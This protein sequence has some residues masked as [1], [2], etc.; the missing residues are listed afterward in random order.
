MNSKTEGSEKSLLKSFTV[1]PGYEIFPNMNEISWK[2]KHNIPF[3]ARYNYPTLRKQLNEVKTLIQLRKIS[4]LEALDFIGT[5]MTCCSET[6]WVNFISEVFD[7]LDIQDKLNI[8]KSIIIE[9]LEDNSEHIIELLNNL[10]I[11]V[12]TESANF[13]SESQEIILMNTTFLDTFFFKPISS[14]KPRKL[15]KLSNIISKLVIN[16]V[17][18]V[19]KENKIRCLEIMVSC[20]FTKPLIKKHHWEFLL[21]MLSDEQRNIEDF[22]GRIIGIF[23]QSQKKKYIKKAYE[24]LHSNKSRVNDDPNNSHYFELTDKA[25]EDISKCIEIDI[26]NEISNEG[27]SILNESEFKKL[28]DILIFSINSNFEYRPNVNLISTLIFVWTNITDKKYFINELLQFGQNACGYGLMMNMV[29]FLG[30]EYI[31]INEIYMQKDEVVKYIQNNELDINENI[32]DSIIE[33]CKNLGYNSEKILK[34]FNL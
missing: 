3:L 11:K 24:L 29:T 34:V 10:F 30:P 8:L 2:L 17:D 20:N 4:S 9:Y 32:K 7:F 28:I 22:S 5:I 15:S 1:I 31:Y 23:L 27:R 19:T 6:E 33:A 21:N 14:M 13:T 18:L 16:I 26:I 12:L 25:I